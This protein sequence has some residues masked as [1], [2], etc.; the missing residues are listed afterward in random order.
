V[1]R[2][3]LSAWHDRGPVTLRTLVIEPVASGPV[4]FFFSFDVDA[5]SPYRTAG[6]SAI[7]SLVWCRLNGGEHG[8]SRICD[9]LEQHRVVGNFM[10][11]FASCATE[12]EAKLAEIID[13]LSGRGHEVHLHLHPE[14]L[15]SPTPRAIERDRLR[16]LSQSLLDQVTYDMGWSMLDYAITLYE[17]F[18]QR[19]P[20]VFRSGSY[21]VNAEL[22]KAAGSLGI[23]AL[24]NVRRDTIPDRT[25]RGGDMV[26]SHE[27]FA[28]ENGVIEIP[29]DMG[30]PEITTLEKYE[31]T[32]TKIIKQ[33]RYERTFN[34]VM[35]SWSLTSRN[36]EGANDTSAPDPETRL[37]EMCMHATKHGRARGYGEYL[38][39]TQT[40]R[41][42]VRASAI[43]T[44]S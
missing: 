26:E 39:Q 18:A 29:V 1:H 5:N 21:R 35:H 8:I 3:G 6:D 31:R 7:D 16:N 19:A 17:R 22:V 23:E 33:K 13:H 41:P 20:R 2:I 28:W 25:L 11:D 43:R 36:E 37:H 14:D 40:S 42:T 30:S 24:S 34:L 12:G 44:R 4:D 9:V 32:Y 38:D 15:P 27:P 10:I